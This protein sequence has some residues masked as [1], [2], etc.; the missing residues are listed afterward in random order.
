MSAPYYTYAISQ[1][2]HKLSAHAKITSILE[3]A[4]FELKEGDKR[5]ITAEL[6]VQ[7]AIEVLCD[8]DLHRCHCPFPNI[9]TINDTCYRGRVEQDICDTCQKIIQTRIIR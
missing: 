7:R 5:N 6:Y 1:G 3:S 9:R 4:L 2:T 8:E